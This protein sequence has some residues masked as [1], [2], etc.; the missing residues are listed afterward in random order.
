MTLRDADFVGDILV[1]GSY[2]A[3]RSGANSSSK[4]RR[5]A[6]A[7]YNRAVESDLHTQYYEDRRE[8]W[9]ATNL[10]REG[11]NYEEGRMRSGYGSPMLTIDQKTV[12]A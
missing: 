10:R 2:L 4:D 5:A 11:E 6:Y 8:L 3:H 12:A 7:T 9:P 1:F